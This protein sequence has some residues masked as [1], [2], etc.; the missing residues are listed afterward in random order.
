[1]M[2]VAPRSP[3]GDTWSGHGPKHDCPNWTVAGRDVSRVQTHRDSEIVQE[4]AEASSEGWHW[5]NAK[6][7]RQPSANAAREDHPPITYELCKHERR[8]EID[9]NI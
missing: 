6:G 2:A 3:L 4:T 1:M 7:R 8:H 9:G 5:P